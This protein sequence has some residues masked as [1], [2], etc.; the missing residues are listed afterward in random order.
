[1][2]VIGV[3]FDDILCLSCLRD[4][5]ISLFFLILGLELV[6]WDLILRFLGVLVGIFI[7]VVVNE[8]LWVVG[9]VN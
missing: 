9:V 2:W 1:M 6:F 7:L 4:R 8:R 5:R 3:S